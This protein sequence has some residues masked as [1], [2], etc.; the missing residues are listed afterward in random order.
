MTRDEAM[1]LAATAWCKPETRNIVMDVR[2]AKAF[3]EILERE[4][5]RAALGIDDTTT[6]KTKFVIGKQAIRQTFN[7]L[8]QLHQAMD[9][10]VYARS[11]ADC[12][13]CGAKAALKCTHGGMVYNPDTNEQTTSA[14]ARCE[15]CGQIE[16][17]DFVLVPRESE[18]SWTPQKIDVLADLRKVKETMLQSTSYDPSTR[19][20]TVEEYAKTEGTHPRGKCIDCGCAIGQHH[21][22]GCKINPV[23]YCPAC[24]YPSMC[25]NENQQYFCAFG[26]SFTDSTVLVK[27]IRA[28]EH[29]RDLAKPIIAGS[30]ATPQA[31]IRE[32]LRKV[33]ETALK[34]P[35]VD[36]G[37]LRADENSRL[38]MAEDAPPCR[39]PD[40]VA[41][42]HPDC[43][44]LKW[45]TS[46]A[47]TA[48]PDA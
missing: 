21:K 45:R 33:A 18:I 16:N 25:K 31:S 23:A 48:S 41:G 12:V 28:E 30:W 7:T 14:R 20:A 37:I 13:S 38:M 39:C 32:Q 10:F 29:A 15:V 6:T 46:K 19:V 43:E 8:K 24:G 1:G 2:L 3:A 42:H 36:P 35:T 22:D 44:F 11:H 9:E 26:C 5:A 17:H 4:T 27:P 34:S 40:L 47:E